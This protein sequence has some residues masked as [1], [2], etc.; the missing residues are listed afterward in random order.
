[1]EDFYKNKRILI[2]GHT[3][4]KGTWLCLYLLKFKAKIFGYSL[5]PEKNS[6]Y[7]Q[8]EKYL[9]DNIQEHYE[10]ILNSD[11]LAEVIKNVQ[12][13][14]IFHLAAQPLVRKSYDNPI[15]TWET[16]LIGSLNLLNSLK[17]YSKKCAVL[18]ITTDKVY[19]NREWE[20]GYRENDILSGNDPYS[21]SKA[22]LEIAVSSW[23]FSFCG[24]KK[25]QNSNISIAT[26]RAGNV[27]G[28]GDMAADRIV[29]DC[30]RSLIN[31][32]KIII[33]NPDSTRPWQHV[34]EPLNGYL[35]LAMQLYLNPNKFS[36][37]F[38]FGPDIQNNTSVENLVQQILK[39]WNGEY[40]IHKDSEN[41]YESSLLHLQIDKVYK[42]LNWYPKW[43]FS[44]TVKKTI[45]WYKNVFEGL[46]PLEMCKLDIEDYHN[47][48]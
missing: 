15:E 23:R 37:A 25:Y 8:V 3:G 2:T 43:D 6:L 46:S 17:Q 27:I 36:S 20:F 1:M 40:L 38:N 28:G 22:A 35:L 29:P 44:K 41:Y 30:I 21:A 14:I 48:T 7:L 5:T 26:A 18:V 39:S 24:N 47:Q 11:K 32:E 9:K 19:L 31:N 33:R 45:L 42:K 4:F 34:L 12:P 10:N 13:D 16:N